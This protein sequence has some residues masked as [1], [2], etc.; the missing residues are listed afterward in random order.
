MMLPLCLFFLL[1]FL[2]ALCQASD[3]V[4]QKTDSRV[5]HDCLKTGRKTTPDGQGFMI[6]SATAESVG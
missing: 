4:C 5:E 3:G 2:L 6:R 1:W